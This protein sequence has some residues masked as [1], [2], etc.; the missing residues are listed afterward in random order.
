MLFRL[1]AD[2]PFLPHIQSLL[3]EQEPASEETATCDE[4]IAAYLLTMSRR[5]SESGFNLVT[6]FIEKFRQCLNEKAE[7]ICEGAAEGLYCASNTA[8]QIPETANYF[9]S[10]YLENTHTSF[11]RDTAI[12]LTMHFCRWL[13]IKRYSNLKLSIND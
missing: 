7:E 3:S 10:E 13:Y 1:P 12:S 9:I 8:Q 4:V 6:E 11:D 5:L 2:C